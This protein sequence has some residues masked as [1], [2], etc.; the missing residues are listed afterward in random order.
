MTSPYDMWQYWRNTEDAD[1][2]KFL[3]LF[4]TLPMAEIAK[5]E[6]LGGAEINEAKKILAFEATKLCHSAAEATEAAETARNTFEQGG[7]GDN[8]PTIEVPENDLESGITIVEILKQTGLVASNGEAKRLIE[9]NGA[10]INDKI[11]SASA[12]I[13]VKA[14]LTADGYIKVSSGKKKHAL[15]KIKA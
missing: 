12:H 3:K 15:V 11:I 1:V 7:V 13:V 10:K 2:G 8:L 4:T 5:L 14:D 6:A 9:G